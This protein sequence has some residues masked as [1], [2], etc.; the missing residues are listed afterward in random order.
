MCQLRKRS[1]EHAMTFSFLYT[2]VYHN[3]LCTIRIRLEIEGKFQN[4]GIARSRLVS[5]ISEYCFAK[6]HDAWNILLRILFHLLYDKFFKHVDYLQNKN[7]WKIDNSSSCNMFENF[8][9]NEIVPLLCMRLLM[10]DCKLITQTNLFSFI[11]S[12]FHISHNIKS[13]RN[14][15]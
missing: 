14:Q 6:L 4:K 2:I 3:I 15:I 10:R 9:I 13:S 8:T 5:I 12:F 7:V 1:E 11:D